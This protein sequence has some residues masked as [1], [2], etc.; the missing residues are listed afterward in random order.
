VKLKS[1]LDKIGKFTLIYDDDLNTK[2]NEIY[3]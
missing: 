2:I 1:I 3:G